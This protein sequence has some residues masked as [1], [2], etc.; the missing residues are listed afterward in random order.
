MLQ[1]GT[2]REGTGRFVEGRDIGVPQQQPQAQGQPRAVQDNTG[3]RTRSDTA[4]ADTGS[5]ENQAQYSGFDK[6]I[7]KW[8]LGT[9]AST[10]RD[11]K[12][13]REMDGDAQKITQFKEVV[14]GLQDFRT[15]LFMKPGSAFVTVMHSPMKFVAISDATQHLQGRYIGFVGDRTATKDPT[16]IVLPQQKTWSWETMV[17]AT[18]ADTMAA[19]YDQDNTRRG[20]LWAPTIGGNEGGEDTIKAPVLLAIPLLLFQALRA[21]NKPLMPHEA[22]E[23]HRQ[24]RTGCRQ[25]SSR[26]GSSVILVSPGSTAK[27]GGQ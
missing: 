13:Q 17:V 14:G 12:W 25:G 22:Y 20:N 4:A 26:L 23:E 15:Y 7:K 6:A 21:E 3:E 9:K 16:A 1:L 5:Q 24:C 19:Y 11:L 10:S 2:Q 8:G 18:D 27:F